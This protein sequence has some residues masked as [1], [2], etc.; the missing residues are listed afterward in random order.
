VLD[1]RLPLGGEAPFHHLLVRLGE[2]RDA[3]VLTEAESAQQK[4]Q[5]LAL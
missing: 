5:R 1:E 4:D 3:G 2:A